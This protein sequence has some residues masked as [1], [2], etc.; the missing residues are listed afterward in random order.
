[1]TPIILQTGQ[2][3][4]LADLLGMPSW[5][6]FV[7]ML[8]IA[9]PIGLSILFMIGYTTR[10]TINRSLV[11][12]L[13]KTKGLKLQKNDNGIYDIHGTYRG[14]KVELK[15]LT[16][17]WEK[18]R[19]MSIKLSHNIPNISEEYTYEGLKI[20]LKFV[21]EELEDWPEDTLPEI[22]MLRARVLK[23]ENDPSLLN[24]S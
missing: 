11:A 1:M 3:G 22:N 6:C 18:P 16:D 20:D 21:E 15:H 19:R 14:R 5:G 13:G 12:S 4:Q 24:E 8:A 17:I 23:L 10:S 2:D 9:I 7:V